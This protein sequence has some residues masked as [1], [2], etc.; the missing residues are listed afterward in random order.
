MEDD[1]NT[2]IGDEERL[3]LTPKPVKVLE[4]SVVAVGEAKKAKKIELSCKHPD[5]DEAI[6]MSNV[7]IENKGKLENSGLWLNKDSKGNLQKG[8]VLTNFLAFNN[9]KTIGE[10]VGKELITTADEKKY[11]VFKAY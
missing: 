10:L 8:S 7:K 4:V 3:T 6:K 5:R 2:P 11:L 1:L 9:C